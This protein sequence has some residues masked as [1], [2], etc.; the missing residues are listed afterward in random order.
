MVLFATACY[1]DAWSTP[2]LE[3]MAKLHHG[4][5]SGMETGSIEDGYRSYS[6]D[7]RDRQ[8]INVV[9]KATQGIRILFW[10]QVLP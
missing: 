7:Q 3:T 9:G 2:I 10:K 1:V 4:Y 8:G 6:F 5:K